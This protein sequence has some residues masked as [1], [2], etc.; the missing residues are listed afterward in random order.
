[1]K[2][3]TGLSN[4]VRRIDGGGKTTSSA[5][6]DKKECSTPHNNKSLSFYLRCSENQIINYGILNIIS[7]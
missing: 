7:R 1:M 3:E 2:G 6:K 5:N 4:L